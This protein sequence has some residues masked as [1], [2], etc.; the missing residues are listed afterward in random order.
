MAALGLASAVYHLA[1]DGAGRTP[2]SLLLRLLIFSFLAAVILQ[3]ILL[4]MGGVR[5]GWPATV[6]SV[7]SDQPMVE[8]SVEHL[9]G[10]LGVPQAI[11]LRNE[12]GQPQGPPPPRCLAV[13]GE[14]DD[15]S[16]RPSKQE[17]RPGRAPAG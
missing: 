1:A 17:G 8:Q 4:P 13:N 9:Q 14:G 5:L 12:V 10:D 11:P 16:L 15:G 7:A 6:D 2:S 3:L